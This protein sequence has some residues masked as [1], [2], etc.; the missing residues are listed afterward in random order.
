MKTNQP[1]CSWSVLSFINGDGK[2]VIMLWRAAGLK[3]SQPRLV[4]T[5]RIAHTKGGSKPAY[6]DTAPGVVLARN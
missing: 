4:Q 2:R 5:R 6:P 1:H 3:D